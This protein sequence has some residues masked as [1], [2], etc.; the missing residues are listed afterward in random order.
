MAWAGTMDDYR[1]HLGV[2]SAPTVNWCSTQARWA[3]GTTQAT[4]EEAARAQ[5]CQAAVVEAAGGRDA[6]MLIAPC[7][8][9]RSSQ[10][11]TPGAPAVDLAALR[12]PESYA[13]KL[14][15]L[16]ATVQAL[17]ERDKVRVIAFQEVKSAEAAQEVLGPFADRFEVCA[18][19][20]NSFQ[21]LVFAWDKSLSDVKGVCSTHAAL[22]VLDPPT[23]PAAFRRVRPGLALQ[24]SVNGAPVTFMNVHLKAACASVTSSNPRFPARLLT[25]PVEAC[26]VFNRQV[27]LLEDWIETVAARSP[28]FVILGDFNRR[29]DEEQALAL[30]KDQ[31]R[32]DGSDPASPNPVGADG[33]VKTRYLW[34]EIADGSPGLFQLPLKAR[35]AACKGFEGL[36]HIVVSASLHAVLEQRSPAEMGTRKAAVLGRAG[37]LMETSD[38]CPQIGRLLL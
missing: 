14:A 2:C 20:H 35:D 31:V 37:Q 17:I 21:T 10:P 38:H 4:P 22:A 18:A 7:S 27:P 36:D 13:E 23:D 29:I 30:V 19:Q 28:R 34:P 15:G 11:R 9:Y 5:A 8:A 33:R 24:L 16:R 6:S 32:S 3:P 25:D 1:K 12:K 26:E